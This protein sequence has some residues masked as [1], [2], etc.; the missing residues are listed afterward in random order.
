MIRR[1]VFFAIIV[2]VWGG[3]FY[4]CGYRKSVHD[5]GYMVL[6]QDVALPVYYESSYRH[7]YPYYWKT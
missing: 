7:I 1:L 4:I 5:A 3:W 6:Y 2:P